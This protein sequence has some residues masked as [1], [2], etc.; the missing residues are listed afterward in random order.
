MSPAAEK[1]LA[2]F[3]RRELAHHERY[4]SS[5][6]ELASAL[7]KSAE[8]REHIKAAYVRCGA[9][10]EAIDSLRARRSRP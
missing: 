10:I 9:A 1:V 5:L 8:L 6:V 7:P 3:L 2:V 4:L